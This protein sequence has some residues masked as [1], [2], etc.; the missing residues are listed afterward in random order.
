MEQYFL[1]PRIHNSSSYHQ[2]NSVMNVPITP[3]FELP[4][5]S[6]PIPP[7]FASP[8]FDIGTPMHT[9]RREASCVGSITTT[10]S[11]GRIIG[12]HSYLS[13]NHVT[14]P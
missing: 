10:T 4:R 12:S 13:P 1:R 2:M 7:I 8:Q 9:H 6:N 11:D 5:L 3:L 14:K